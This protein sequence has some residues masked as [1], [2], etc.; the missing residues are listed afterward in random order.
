MFTRVVIPGSLPMVLTGARLALNMSLVLVIAGELLVAQ[1][2]LGQAMWFSWQTMRITDVYAW[3][4]VTG[5]IGVL[6]NRA[7]ALFSGWVMPWR[8]DGHT[9][10][11]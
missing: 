3:L 9:R 11:R 7:L 4:V 1:R 10:P 6:L 5:A 2:G 8:E